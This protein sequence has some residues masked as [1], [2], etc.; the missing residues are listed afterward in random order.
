[1]S[2]CRSASSG[3]CSNATQTWDLNKINITRGW[4]QRR[5][6]QTGTVPRGMWR[7]KDGHV[8]FM[9]GSGVGLPFKR[10]I[11][12]MVQWIAS[13]GMA[14]ALLKQDW[15]QD[16]APPDQEQ[17]DLLVAEAAAFFLTKTTQQLY[18]RAARDHILLAPIS[19]AKDIV[20]SP[21]LRERGY[22]VAVEHPEFGTSIVYPNAFVRTSV[23]SP[24]LQ[25]RAPLIGEHNQE[26][27]HQELGYTQQQVV[28]LREAGVI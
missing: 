15:N 13:E 10:S 14:D 9:M 1:M 12:A 18:E 6:P 23:A 20:E 8:A 16:A 3:P 11:E 27:F 5:D 26:I 22:F 19:S 2:P 25:R 4:S 17:Y 24:R 7:C 28:T 21:Q